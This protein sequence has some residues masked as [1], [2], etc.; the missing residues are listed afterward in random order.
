MSTPP[1]TEGARGTT[2]AGGL[3]DV[4]LFGLPRPRLAGGVISLVCW[5]GKLSTDGSVGAAG[6]IA[7][8]SILEVAA[9][10]MEELGG[11]L[12]STTSSFTLDQPNNIPTNKS[13]E[14]QQQKINNSKSHN[15]NLIACGFQS[16]S[17]MI[18]VSAA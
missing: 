10:E 1:A 6:G 18:T 9:T 13:L 11:Q 14:H 16:V 8:G 15:R 4:I 7:A 17:N 5:T 12:V 3:S 2:A